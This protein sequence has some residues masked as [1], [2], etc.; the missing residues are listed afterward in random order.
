MSTS[1]VHKMPADLQKVL[2]SSP[3]TLI[4]WEDITPLARNEWLCWIESAK[5]TETR[6]HRIKRTR[7][8]LIEG[9]RRPCCWA[10]CIHR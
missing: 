2:N 7:T 1:M 4:A 5:K 6:I 10:G 8:E 3:S 9:R